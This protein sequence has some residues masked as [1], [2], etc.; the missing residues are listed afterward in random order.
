M[1]VCLFIY[2]SILYHNLAQNIYYYFYSQT[3]QQ[4]LNKKFLQYMSFR[5]AFDY[6]TSRCVCV[7]VCVCACVCVCVCVCAGGWVGVW[8]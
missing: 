8:G 6:T 3:H 4:D 7:C 5:L 1:H 2:A